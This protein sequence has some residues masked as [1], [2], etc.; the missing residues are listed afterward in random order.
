MPY[1]YEIIILTEYANLMASRPCHDVIS[2]QMYHQLCGSLLRIAVP[3]PEA[4]GLPTTMHTVTDA[5]NRQGKCNITPI[6]A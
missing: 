4:V 2:C 6:Q 3:K 1:N 5:S